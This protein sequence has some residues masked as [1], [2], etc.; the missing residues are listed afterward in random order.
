MDDC[1]VCFEGFG[2]PARG[3]MRLWCG[4]VYHP[5]CVAAL[6]DDA[7]PL[8]RSPLRCKTYTVRVSVGSNNLS[9]DAFRN[10]C[11]VDGLEKRCARNTIK[12]FI[13]NESA[14]FELV[15]E[16]G[17]IYTVRST[18]ETTSA[19]VHYFTLHPKS[20]SRILDKTTRD[21]ASLTLVNQWSR[22][23]LMPFF[24]GATG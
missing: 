19:L 11:R 18:P 21:V 2:T 9:F 3:W 23:P 14:I 13:G 17:V 1:C 5:H 8:C 15:S 7:C 20:T 22:M 4:H 24:Y 6:L 10:P 16:P 12:D